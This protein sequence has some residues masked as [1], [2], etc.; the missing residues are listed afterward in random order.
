MADVF[1]SH[2]HEEALIATAVQRYLQDTLKRET[3][4]FPSSDQWQ[5]LA[6]ENW[7]ARI[8]RELQSATVVILLLSHQ[9]VVRPWVNF[10]AGAAW[11]ADK[12][13]IPTCFGD[14]HKDELPR[15]YG[16]LQAVYLPDEANYFAWCVASRLGAPTIASETPA[17]GFHMERHRLYAA[18][19]QFNARRAQ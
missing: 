4:I 7:L 5:V 1:I 14:Q 16:D 13:V 3:N 6:G 17:A 18:F 10:E 2:I 8:K 11:L 15:P 12:V 9:S 19:K